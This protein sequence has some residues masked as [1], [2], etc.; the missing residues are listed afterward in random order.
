MLNF[1]IVAEHLVKNLLHAEICQSTALLYH[2]T[3]IL[4]KKS[5]ITTIFASFG[6][7]S[8]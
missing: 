8:N 4:G 6:T 1:V 5:T 3:Y 2:Y 7:I